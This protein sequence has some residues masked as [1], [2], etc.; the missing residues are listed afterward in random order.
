MK[1]RILSSVPFFPSLFLLD[2]AFCKSTHV[3]ITGA[4]WDS[5]WQGTAQSKLVFTEALSP[6]PLVSHC[7]FKI[8]CFQVRKEPEKK[9][10][11]EVKKKEKEPLTSV[12]PRCN[13]NTRDISSTSSTI[14]E[15]PLFFCCRDKNSQAWGLFLS[16]RTRGIFFYWKKDGILCCGC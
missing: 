14:Q 16:F 6:Q 13:N 3:H 1:A 11:R 4:Y 5:Q 8:R 10:E 7:F 15:E 2:Y 9:R 12:S